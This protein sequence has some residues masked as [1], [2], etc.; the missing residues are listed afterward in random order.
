MAKITGS[1]VESSTKPQ[2][3]QTKKSTK[4]TLKEKVRG[5]KNTCK[6][7]LKFII[8]IFGIFKNAE[9]NQQQNFYTPQQPPPTFYQNYPTIPSASQKS[10]STQLEK[11]H[12]R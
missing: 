11:W 5:C 2:N 1:Q 7:I 4:T 6:F 3:G 12:H 10:P 9:A 8:L